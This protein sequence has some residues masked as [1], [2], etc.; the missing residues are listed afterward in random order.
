MTRRSI[1]TKVARDKQGFE[2]CCV[3]DF[4]IINE[5]MYEL[6][7]YCTSFVM[8]SLDLKNQN[9]CFSLNRS[10]RASLMYIV[11]V[12]LSCIH[13][14]YPFSSPVPTCVDG[15]YEWHRHM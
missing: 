12:Y 4:S 6:D 3:S 10:S 9:L 8:I 14:P 15:M 7:I 13:I 1:E 11:R 2:M 5:W